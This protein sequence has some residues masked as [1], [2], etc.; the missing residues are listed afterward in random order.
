MLSKAESLQTESLIF[1]L[2]RVVV[3]GAAIGLA[4]VGLFTILAGSHLNLL[5]PVVFNCTVE[6]THT[7]LLGEMVNTFTGLMD[8]LIES[9]LVQDNA[10]SVVVTK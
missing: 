3:N 5:P 6:L 4:I 9:I 7:E 8:I 10:A 2:K 1:T